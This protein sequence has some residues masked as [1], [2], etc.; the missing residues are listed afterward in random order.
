MTRIDRLRPEFVEFVPEHPRPGILYVSRRYA[1]AV[2]LCCCGC[3]SE[4]VTPLNPVKWHLRE[5]GGTV[6]LSPSIGNWSLPCQS[7][8]WIENDRV[9]WAAA[10][11]PEVIAAVKARDRRDA[12][13][14]APEPGGIFARVRRAITRAFDL[15]RSK[16]SRS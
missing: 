15:F 3:G 6:S 2:H 7:H 5:N 13:A 16:F 11:E 9:V 4:V 14:L 1:T 8:Y 12:A 10:M